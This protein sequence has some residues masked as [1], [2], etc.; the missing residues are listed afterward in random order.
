MLPIAID[1]M[2]G[3]QQPREYVA[4]ALRALHDDVGLRVL[5][6]AVNDQPMRAYELKIP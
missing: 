2:S 4:G 3:D 6:V 1:V 5:L